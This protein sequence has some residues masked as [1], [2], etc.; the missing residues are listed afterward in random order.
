MCYGLQCY[1]LFLFYICI[2]VAC[3]K[4]K[5]SGLLTRLKKKEEPR[6]QRSVLLL[7]DGTSYEGT[8]FGSQKRSVSGECVFQTGS[9]NFNN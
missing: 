1:Y 7:A 5:F 6:M 2:F 3:G 4:V 8:A 9:N